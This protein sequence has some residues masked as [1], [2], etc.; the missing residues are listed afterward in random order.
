LDARR[1]F[2]IGKLETVISRLEAGAALQVTAMMPVRRLI[3][4]RHVCQ[5]FYLHLIQCSH[6]HF[7]RGQSLSGASVLADAPKGDLF[8]SGA[9][10]LADLYSAAEP[11]AQVRDELS[12]LAQYLH[13]LSPGWKRKSIHATRSKLADPD[14]LLIERTIVYSLSDLYDGLGAYELCRYFC[15]DYRDMAFSLEPK[16]VG[17]VREVIDFFLYPANG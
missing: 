14:L 6:Q 1:D 16:A 15:C 17:R 13:A 3:R 7:E 2:I 9:D 10:L 5:R 11:S 4:E 12:E 8:A